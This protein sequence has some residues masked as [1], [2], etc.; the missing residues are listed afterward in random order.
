MD[1]TIAD[2]FSALADRWE[3]E[4]AFLSSST[5]IAEH[6]AYQEI[7]GM[8]WDAVPLIIGRLRQRSGHWFMALHSITGEDPVDPADAGRVERMREA[9]LRLAAERGWESS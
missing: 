9:W 4:T 2:R 5:A 6:P 8:G 1:Q 3:E 7:I